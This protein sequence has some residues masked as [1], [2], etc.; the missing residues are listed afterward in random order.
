MGALR[1]RI[2]LGLTGLAALGS[3]TAHGQARRSGSSASADVPTYQRELAYGINFNTNGGMIGGAMFR[4][5]RVLSSDWSRF[6]MLEAVEVKHPKEQRVQNYFSGGIYVPGK[7]NYAFVLRPSFGAQRVIFRKAPDSGVQV[8]ALGSIGP[9]VALLMPYYIYYD[10]TKRDADNQPI[11]PTDIRTEQYDPNKHSPDDIFIYDRAPLFSGAN[12]T[13]PQ[14]GGHVRGALT[15]E[16][17]RYRDAVAGVETGFLFEA[18]P[19]NLPILG[20]NAVSA[21]QLN[22]K[23]FTSVYFT[24]YIGTRK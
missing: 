8:S 4:S 6:W 23:Y 17:G 14:I 12:E 19:K 9:S 20:S 15:F 1:F 10:Y 13:K 22:N 3:Q 18:Y 21:D 5:A 2:L 7:T 16:Y 24:I 11:G